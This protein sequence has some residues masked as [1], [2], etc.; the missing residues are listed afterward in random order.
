VPLTTRLAQDGVKLDALTANVEVRRWLEEVANAR[1][2]GTTGVQ[3]TVRL[4]EE[5]A[6]LQPL[7][8][9]WRGEIAAA[10]PQ[11]KALEAPA[12]IRLPAVV[13]CIGEGTPLQHPLAVYEQLLA[14]V[15]KGAAV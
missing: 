2:H 13:A 14:Q 8:A 4:K 7:L 10:R 3:P 12:P 11:G 6:H 9:P 15:T 1:I 5:Q